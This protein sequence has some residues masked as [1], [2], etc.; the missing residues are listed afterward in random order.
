MT[1]YHLKGIFVFKDASFTALVKEKHAVTNALLIV[2]SVAVIATSLG[3]LV[4]QFIYVPLLEAFFPQV[5]EDMAF[6]ALHTTVLQGVLVALA[7]TVVLAGVVL[8]SARLLGAKTGSYKELLIVFGHAYAIQIVSF[9]PLLLF[10]AWIYSVIVMIKGVSVV[11][12]LSIGRSTAAY[13]LPLGV[14]VVLALVVGII[15]GLL[16]AASVLS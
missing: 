1:L 16:V 6:S 5:L 8:L 7:G 10:P 12:D 9:I 11:T 15:A 2:F 13:L 14:L 4:Q 3:Y